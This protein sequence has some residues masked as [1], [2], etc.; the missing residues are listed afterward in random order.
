MNK[1][2]EIKIKYQD[3]IDGQFPGEKIV[4]I[5]NKDGTILTGIFS[6][7]NIKEDALTAWIIQETEN[8]YLVELPNPTL[9]NGSKAW[10]SKD[11]VTA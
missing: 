5:I 7:N 6:D 2:R 3:I 1:N 9:T 10:V 4:R 8:D 11:L